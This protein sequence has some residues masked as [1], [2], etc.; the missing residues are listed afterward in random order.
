MKA[1]LTTI[2]LL[3]LMLL[4]QTGFSGLSHLVSLKSI[5]GQYRNHNKVQ[6]ILVNDGNRSIFLDPHAP[7]VAQVHKFDESTGKWYPWGLA[8]ECGVSG[9][10]SVHEIKPGT[11]HKVFVQWGLFT[12][13]QEGPPIGKYKISVRYAREPWTIDK[14]PDQ[15]HSV[16]SKEFKISR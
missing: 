14:M 1:T 9:Q 7:R 11:N 10:S 15:I 2:F 4:P 13:D 16:E 6:P 5:R 8:G 12:T 3:S